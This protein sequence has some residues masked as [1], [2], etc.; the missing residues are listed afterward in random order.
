MFHRVGLVWL[1]PPTFAISYASGVFFFF[2]AHYGRGLLLNTPGQVTP[3]LLFGSTQIQHALQH[4][5]LVFTSFA[6]AVALIK[7]ALFS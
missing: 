1:I 5:K 4:F 7:L 6:V 2:F 3:L